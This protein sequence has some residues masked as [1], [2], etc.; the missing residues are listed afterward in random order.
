MYNSNLKL[1]VLPRWEDYP[2]RRV[3]SIEVEDWLKTLKY[4]AAGSRAKIRNLMSTIFRHAIRWGWIGQHENPIT[5]V[6]VS[7]KRQ[8]GV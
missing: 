3:T 5:L 2:L 6:R 7:A 4:L 8:V 1:Y